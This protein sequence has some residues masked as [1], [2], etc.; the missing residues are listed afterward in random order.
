MRSSV[1][2]VVVVSGM[3]VG[4]IVDTAG[5]V[6][7][8]GDEVVVDATLVSAT[9]V[10]TTGATVVAMEAPLLLQAASAAV[11]T[12][13]TIDRFICTQCIRSA[14]PHH[15]PLYALSPYPSPHS[16]PQRTMPKAAKRK[17]SGRSAEVWPRAAMVA[18]WGHSSR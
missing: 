17:V 7:V 3:V 8:V 5:A 1:A 16:Y 6:V 2:T 4:V 9:A 13:I 15:T 11:A 12:Q 18:A 14:R 10:V